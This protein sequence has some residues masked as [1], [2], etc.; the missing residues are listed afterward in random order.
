MIVKRFVV[1][2]ELDDLRN[3]CKLDAILD[4]ILEIERMK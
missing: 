4:S 1:I 2:C 3:M